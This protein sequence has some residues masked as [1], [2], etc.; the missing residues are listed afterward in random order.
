MNPRLRAII[1]VVIMSAA[2]TLYF[3]FVGV[4][5]VALL[6]SG[7]LI[8]V[9]MGAALLFMPL[10]GVWALWREIRFGRDATRLA[11]RL[12]AEGTLPDDEVEVL[13]SGKPV[14]EDADAAFPRYRAEVE[15]A[16]ESWAAWMRLG[17]VYDA[18]G[19]RKRARAAIREAI[20]LERN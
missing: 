17:I 19:D 9:V 10:L 8:A 12:E 5:A 6:L 11:D 4:R 3:L 18:C 2:L 16:P 20:L 13:P 1:G 7:D 15:A 14:R